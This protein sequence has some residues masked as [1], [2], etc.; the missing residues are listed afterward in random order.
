[1]ST[2]ERLPSSIRDD[3]FLGEMRGEINLE[4]TG[5]QSGKSLQLQKSSLLPWGGMDGLTSTGDVA[6]S[7][8]LHGG[9]LSLTQLIRWLVS[10][11]QVR[12]KNRPRLADRERHNWVWGQRL[13][14]P[15]TPPTQLHACKWYYAIWQHSRSK[16]KSNVGSRSLLYIWYNSWLCIFV[17]IILGP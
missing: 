16:C 6:G 4:P 3:D 9:E 15:N 7:F 5:W 14:K 2:D 1:M 8:E 10:T 11:V 13:W 17:A 12:A